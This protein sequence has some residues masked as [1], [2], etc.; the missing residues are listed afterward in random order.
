MK[1]RDRIF[2]AIDSWRDSSLLRMDFFV[3]WRLILQSI[4]IIGLILILIGCSE[5][6]YKEN[7]A[8]FKRVS[9]GTQT[10]VSEFTVGRDPGGKITFEMKGYQSDQVQAIGAV[11]EGVAKG[12]AQG[13]KP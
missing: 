6:V 11:A 8:E 10:Q 7:G 12:L 2:T 9:F 5:V 4:L 1:I 3:S 13:I